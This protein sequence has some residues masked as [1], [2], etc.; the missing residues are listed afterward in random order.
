MI[1]GTDAHC[2]PKG[3]GEKTAVAAQSFSSLPSV[4]LGRAVSADHL[5]A[6]RVESRPVAV[7]R[8]GGRDKLSRW[9]KRW[10]LTARSAVAT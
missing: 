2:I 1:C 10:E 4:P 5:L 6:G 7:L 8:E 9:K 3:R